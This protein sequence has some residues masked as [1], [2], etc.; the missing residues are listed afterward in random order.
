MRD[1]RSTVNRVATV[2]LNQ[3]IL[4]TVIIQEVCISEVDREWD[5]IPIISRTL[6][7]FDSFRHF[8][9]V[10]FLLRVFWLSLK[11]LPRRSLFPC[12]NSRLAY[13]STLDFVQKLLAPNLGN[14]ISD[15]FGKMDIFRFFLARADISLALNRPTQE[16]IT[17]LSVFKKTLKF[18]KSAL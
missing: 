13:T 10:V 16:E 11:V 6:T 3:I 17:D 4:R 14:R 1:T 15:R 2:G 5:Q 12:Q 8:V 18:L 7:L 9:K